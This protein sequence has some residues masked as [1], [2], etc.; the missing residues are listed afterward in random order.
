MRV[1]GGDT[2]PGSV[3][4]SRVREAGCG[5]MC[6]VRARRG[7]EGLNP[8]GPLGRTSMCLRHEQG[9]A[10]AMKAFVYLMPCSPGLGHL[11]QT[12]RD[13]ISGQLREVAV[14]PGTGTTR[15]DRKKPPPRTEHIKATPM[16]SS[17]SYSIPRS[18]GLAP[19]RPLIQTARPIVN[20]T[21]ATSGSS[22]LVGVCHCHLPCV[23]GTMRPRGR[24]IMA[25]LPANGASTSSAA[26]TPLVDDFD[27]FAADK[28][29]VILYDGVCNLCNGAGKHRYLCWGN[30]GYAW[31]VGIR[32]EG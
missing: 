15:E 25:A 23:T 11:K 14:G 29:P 7:P 19:P 31:T 2:S 17:S 1:V 22:P 4:P 18:L 8:C 16:I 32:K 28:R 6:R 10:T 20:L 24:P 3:T 9:R 30:G 27:D 12:G 13:S 5:C 21:R 26:V